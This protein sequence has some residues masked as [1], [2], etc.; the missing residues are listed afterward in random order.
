MLNDRQMM[1][2]KALLKERFCDLREEIREELLRSDEEHFID[3][4]RLQA[5]S[6]QGPGDR[7]PA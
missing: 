5:R 6:T 2:F 7:D 3:L 4:R 1:E